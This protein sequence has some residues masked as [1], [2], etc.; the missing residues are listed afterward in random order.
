METK[1]PSHIS[2]GGGVN[3]EIK[4]LDERGMIPRIAAIPT[5]AGSEFF[6]GVSGITEGSL[7]WLLASLVMSSSCSS[8]FSM[9]LSDSLASSTDSEIE[10]KLC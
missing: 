1:A 5:Q 10:K 6:K 3:E 7:E 4:Q 8:F 2:G 9:A